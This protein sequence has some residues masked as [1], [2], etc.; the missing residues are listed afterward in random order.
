MTP[1]EKSEELVQKY[2]MNTPVGFHIEDAKECALIAVDEIMYNNL[3]EY[4][5]HSIIYA[6]H[7][8]DYW[9]QVKQELLTFKSE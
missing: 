9:Q 1:K 5:Q 3:M 4:P 8:N 6:P 2:M 7:K